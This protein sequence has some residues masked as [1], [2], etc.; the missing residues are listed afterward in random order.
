LGSSPYD[1]EGVP[2]R[3]NVFVEAGRLRQYV[4]GTYS[5]RKLGMQTTANASGVHN[6]TVDANA[7]GLE[8]I[9]ACMGTGFL[10]TELMGQGVNIITGDYS[11]GASGFWV[12]KGKIKC[13]VQEVTVAGNLKAMFQ[14]IQLVGSDI[15]PNI[16]TRCGS[17]LLAEMTVAG[18]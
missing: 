8:E 18:S 1:G 10:V 9:L 4:L 16:A 11:R 3:D 14:N 15:N 7:S 2:T 5:A 17:V 13:P 12:E 6:L